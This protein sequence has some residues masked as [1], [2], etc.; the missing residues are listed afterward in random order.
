MNYPYITLKNQHNL[1][2]DVIIRKLVVHRDASGSLVETLRN[3]WSD[4]YGERPFT[5]QY[6]STTPSGVARDEDKW[7]VHKFQD[8][9]FICI[10]GRIVTVLFDPREISKT[11]G[12]LNLFLMG[13]QND[14]E[15]YQIVIPKE[16]YH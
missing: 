16:V 8:D 12:T 11:K 10:S 3:D 2:D 7:H 4:V 9:R 15:M 6:I 13:P 5:M 14:D 1:I